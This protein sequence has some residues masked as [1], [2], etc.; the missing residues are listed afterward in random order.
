[1]QACLE[2]AS[3]AEAQRSLRKQRYHGELVFLLRFL[4]CFFHAAYCCSAL[5]AQ[6]VVVTICNTVSIR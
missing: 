2:Q 5:L 6:W 4:F 3:A 1:M